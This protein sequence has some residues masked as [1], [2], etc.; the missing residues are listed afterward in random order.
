MGLFDFANSNTRRWI[1]LL[2][3][4]AISLILTGNNN[5]DLIRPEKLLFGSI[6]VGY[7]FVALLW[8]SY[9]WLRKHVIQ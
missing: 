9:F 5:I 8:I 1:A 2:T 4:I 7:I 3:F 6:K